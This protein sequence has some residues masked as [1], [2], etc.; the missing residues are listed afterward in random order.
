MAP[1]GSTMRAYISTLKMM[2]PKEETKTQKVIKRMFCTA[3]SCTGVASSRGWRGGGGSAVGDAAPLSDA[4]SCI[5]R[6]DRYHARMTVEPLICF[7]G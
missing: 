2:A 3:S 6:G 4:V 1:S 5:G 7:F